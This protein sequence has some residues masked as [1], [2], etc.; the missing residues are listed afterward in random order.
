[1][2]IVRR[3]KRYKILT[4]TSVQTEGQ[5]SQQN[6]PHANTIFQ[7]RRSIHD[8]LKS[9]YVKLESTAAAYN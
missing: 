4:T 2:Q 5:Q 9:P 6:L 7:K 1:M 8:T 3:A